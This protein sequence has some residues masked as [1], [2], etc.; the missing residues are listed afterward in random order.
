MTNRE[1]LYDLLG[2][3][4]P[5]G[6][7][8]SWVAG[9]L[10]CEALRLTQ[11]FNTRITWI[12]RCFVYLVLVLSMTLAGLYGALIYH[13]AV[14][15]HGD[16]EA[17]Q[18]VTPGLRYHFVFNRIATFAGFL[19]YS[20]SVWGSRTGKMKI[21]KIPIIRITI[22][23]V[24]LSILCLFILRTI[25]LFKLS[26]FEQFGS[27][28]MWER[29]AQSVQLICGITLTFIKAYDLACSD[30]IPRV[31][32]MKDDPL[33]F[34]WGVLCLLCQTAIFPTIFDAVLVCLEP[35]DKAVGMS[36]SILSFSAEL[37]LFGP[38]MAISASLDD[39]DLDNYEEPDSPLQKGGFDVADE[40]KKHLPFESTDM[41]SPTYRC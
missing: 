6:T 21:F 3:L 30:E 1:V 11:R 34:A 25:R 36:Y 39:D 15:S 18:L 8:L 22:S 27:S 33:R 9:L 37:H 28:W 14:S 7:C 26:T 20:N 38:I 40:T 2:G 13:Y 16:Y 35:S 23:L 19:F 41:R 31:L 12:R 5:G 24:N 32:A 10:A 4:Q 17:I 29:P